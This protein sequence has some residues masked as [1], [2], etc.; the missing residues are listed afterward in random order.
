MRAGPTPGSAPVSPLCAAPSPPR[1]FPAFSP[2]Q[3]NPRQVSG[4]A[5]R[6]SLLCMNT[7]HRHMGSPSRQDILRHVLGKL[8][9]SR[10]LSMFHIVG[11][12]LGGDCG[13]I[14]IRSAFFTLRLKRSRGEARASPFPLCCER[15]AD[16][17]LIVCLRGGFGGIKIIYFIDN[18]HRSLGF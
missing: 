14:W 12:C 1:F 10:H 5:H 2:I 15:A 17:G 9:S 18:A 16:A 6:A 4:Y 11:P 13:R 7:R 3:H 8:L